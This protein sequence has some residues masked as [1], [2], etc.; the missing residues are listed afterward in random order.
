MKPQIFVIHGG[1][2]T[3][4]YEEYL[5]YLKTKEV[6]LDRLVSKDWKSFLPIK[7]GDA[8]D[9]Y[10]PRMPNS[11]NARYLEWKIYFEKLVPFMLPEV[12]LIG[13]SLGGIFLAKYLSEETLPVKVRATFLVA[14]PFIRPEL[15]KLADFDL[16]L[17]LQKFAEQ[18]GR[19]FIYHSKDD[20]VV[21]V[22]CG[23]MFHRE[24]S[25][26]QLFLFEDRGHFTME[27][28]AELEND[29]RGL[30]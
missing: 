3:N 1:H 24:L 13:H 29:I 30:V 21:P 19:I 20:Q 15:A 22:V 26:S 12:I 11:M 8:F 10:N 23:E 14:A 27:E 4:S 28:F 16:P 7:L 17:S 9:V 25:G 18:G 6:T 2:A 5:A